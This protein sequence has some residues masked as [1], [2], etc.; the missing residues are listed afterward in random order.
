MK[1]QLIRTQHFFKEQI[2]TAIIQHDYLNYDGIGKRKGGKE[3]TKTKKIPPNQQ[4]SC[5]T[6]AG[7]KPF[8]PPWAEILKPFKLCIALAGI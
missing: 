2:N 6:A 3:C 7:V 4:I 1:C 5:N 8:L